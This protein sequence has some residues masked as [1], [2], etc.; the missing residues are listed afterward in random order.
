M[1]IQFVDQDSENGEI[2][3]GSLANLMKS[4]VKVIYQT[5]TSE[6]GERDVEAVW[7]FKELLSRHGISG[8]GKGDPEVR[9]K[10]KTRGGFSDEELDFEGLTD[11]NGVGEQTKEKIKEKLLG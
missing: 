6:K 5:Q 4:K 7:R 9:F 11:I 1:Q 10:V 8:P 2:L 3:S